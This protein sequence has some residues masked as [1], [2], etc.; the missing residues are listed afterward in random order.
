MTNK[1]QGSRVQSL[2]VLYLIVSRRG[3][4]SEQKRR[5]LRDIARLALAEFTRYHRMEA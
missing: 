5:W 1:P 3:K 2:P 4:K